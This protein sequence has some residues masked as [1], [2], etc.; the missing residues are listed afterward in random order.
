MGH[1]FYLRFGKRLFDLASASAGI[2]FIS[3]LLFAAAI[4]VKFSSKG[5]VF[6]R[7]L[8]VG[9]FGK[10]FL[11]LKFRSM[12]L[13]AHK[14]SKLTA[15]GD[16]RITLV[17]N[18]L[19]RTKIDEL[20]QLFNVVLGHMSLVG[21]RPEVPEFTARY[22]ESQS[23]VLRARPGITGPSANV[24][25]EELLASQLDKETFYLQ[26]V[27]PAKLEIDLAYCENISFMTDLSVLYQTFAKLFTR[28]YSPAATVPHSSPRPL[29][30]K[31]NVLRPAVRTKMNSSQL[32]Y[33]RLNQVIIDGCAFAVSLVLAYFI[34]F[35]GSL[36]P[37]ELHQLKYWLPI[38]VAAR[39]LLHGAL[40][41]YRQVWKF[42]SFSDALDIARSIVIVSGLLVILRFALTGQSAFASL[43]RIPLSIIVLDGFLSL[44]L[45][46]S[47]RALRRILYARQ[48]KAEAAAGNAPTSRIFLFGA[49]RAGIML[50][51]EL[52]TNHSYDVIGFIDDDPRK[53]GSV[54]SNTRVVGDGDHLA[55]LVEKYKVD[56]VIISMATASRTTLSRTLAKCRRA[57]VQA[58]IIPSLQEIITGQ[59]QISQFRET[60]VEEVLGRE[61]VE[62]LDFENLAGSAYRGKRILV[63]GAGG[64]IGSEAVRQLLRLKPAAI[65][66]LDKDE[67]SIYELQQ[68]LLLRKSPV[69]IEPLIA[70]VRDIDRLR[71]IFFSFRP[72]IVIHAAA[73]KHVPLMELHPC[74]AILNNVGGTKNVLEVSCEARAERFVFISSDKAV[75]PANVMG[76]T[77]R[78][79]ELLV[80]AFMNNNG[81]R[82]ACVRFGNVLGSRGSV[83]PLFKKQI[84]EGGPVTV[85]HPEITRYF[86]TIQEAV[87]LTLCAGTLAQGGETFVLDMGTPRNIL[88]LAREMILLAGLEPGRD[89]E[90]VIT[91]LRPGEKLFEELVA[92]S[93]TLLNTQFEK[94]SLIEPQPCDA[95]LLLQNISCLIDSAAG[96]EEREI[97]DILSRMGLGFESQSAAPKVF[98]AAS[99]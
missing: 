30:P 55:E 25:E 91:G 54:I 4:A 45:S 74:E 48:R 23:R 21:P 67:N 14:G 80:Q 1:S 18:F 46:M 13:N 37:F 85:T 62:V 35:D 70:N 79:G 75:N 40:G 92:S 88:E 93:E 15:S 39:L 77:K 72:Q 95:S 58:K 34:R 90:T 99:D 26:S 52:E 76:A 78:I 96:N 27:L 50:R 42:L 69:T 6:F 68:E 22:T 65:A 43:A 33:T 11:M 2:L 63:T 28:L 47:A 66:V 20:P 38:L 51:K 9:R 94:L 31:V 8:R 17:G 16:P 60:K 49:G 53:V 29:L 89:I 86:M 56:E 44:S 10:T 3:P 84:A 73:H 19:R 36:G 82:L 5:P 87:Q 41:I 81:V 71:S 7:Q 24:Y 12:R 97:Y 57:N 64:S 32:L 83:I 61:S 98:A 59:V